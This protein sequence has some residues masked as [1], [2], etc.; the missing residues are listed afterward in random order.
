MYA[1]DVELVGDDHG[2]CDSRC[3]KNVTEHGTD[4]NGRPRMTKLEVEAKS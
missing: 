4:Q 2:G 1:P 3:W